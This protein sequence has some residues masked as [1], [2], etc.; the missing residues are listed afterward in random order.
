MSATPNLEGE[1]PPDLV[2]RIMP[3]WHAIRLAFEAGETSVRELS[4]RH[5]V[6]DTAIHKRARAE[7]WTPQKFWFGVRPSSWDE[8]LARALWLTGT[9]IIPGN[10][11][12]LATRAFRQGIPLERLKAWCEL[13]DRVMGGAEKSHRSGHC[14]LWA[15]SMRAS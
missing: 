14:A 8:A 3:D 13:I 6:S 1:E 15:P 7:N 2:G 9:K 11:V 12:P 10:A 5:G 4:R